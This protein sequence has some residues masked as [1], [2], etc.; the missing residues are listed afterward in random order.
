MTREEALK[1]LDTILT[2]GEQVDALEMA[3]EALKEMPVEEYRQ[4]LM[5]V[6]HNSDHDELLAYVVM[7]KEEEFKSLEDILRKHKFEPRT[8]GEWI[9][10]T[11]RPMDEEEYEDIKKEFGELPIEERKMFSCPMP[12]DDQE[13]LICTSWGGVS[14]DR[15][16]LDE[17]GYGLEEN[18]DWDGITAWMPLPEPY[19]EEGDPDE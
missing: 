3:I 14:Q 19:K 2:V 8:H 10:I 17:C 11:Y 16:V 4:R 5:E 6:F 12:E 9:P 13:I 7:P 1:H 18:G 15:C